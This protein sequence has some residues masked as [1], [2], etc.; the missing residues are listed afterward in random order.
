MFKASNKKLFKT[1]QEPFSNTFT[2]SN[3][4]KIPFKDS[5]LTNSATIKFINLNNNSCP[6][7][8]TIKDS[9]KFNKL[10]VELTAFKNLFTLFKR[11]EKE[12]SAKIWDF[13]KETCTSCKLKKIFLG[14]SLKMQWITV[15][16]IYSMLGNYR[17]KQEIWSG[18]TPK[19]DKSKKER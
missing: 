15:S 9:K 17:L 16:K 19:K 6:K 12:F 14:D 5:S 4:Q 10:I 18:N 1:E 8:K 11:K 13:G 3:F 7:P 2:M